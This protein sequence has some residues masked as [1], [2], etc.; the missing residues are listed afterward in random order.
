MIPCPKSLFLVERFVWEMGWRQKRSAVLIVSRFCE[1]IFAESYTN[2]LPIERLFG[3]NLFGRILLLF[4]WTVEGRRPWKGPNP[5]TPMITIDRP[6]SL[7][8]RDVSPTIFHPN[9]SMS[10]VSRHQQRPTCR[11][12]Q[13]NTLYIH[14]KHSC[15]GEV[16]STLVEVSRPA[17]EESRTREESQMDLIRR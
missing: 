14:F 9:N 5:W 15:C 10:L 3:W 12:K 11:L 13:K 1:D 16:S 4:R 6:R 8:R 7:T 2:I 17:M